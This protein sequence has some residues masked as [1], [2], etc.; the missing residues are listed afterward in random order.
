MLSVP[1]FVRPPDHTRL[2]PLSDWY[3]VVGFVSHVHSG[4]L[5][6]SPLSTSD[7]LV[8]N[9]PTLYKHHTPQSVWI[10]VVRL[11]DVRD[12]SAFSRTCKAFKQ[13]ALP[14]LHERIVWVNARQFAN[15]VHQWNLD[16]QLVTHV[17][18]LMLGITEVSLESTITIQGLGDHVTH[19]LPTQATDFV[20]AVFQADLWNSESF[21]TPP[22]YHQIHSL[23]SSCINLETLVFRGT[24]V[25]PSWHTVIHELPRL[26]ILHFR[27][28][29]IMEPIHRVRHSR[30]CI[31]ELSL[32]DVTRREEYHVGNP[33]SAIHP[34]VMDAI[35]SSDSIIS[36]HLDATGLTVL[37]FSRITKLSSPNL[38]HLH[39]HKYG[40]DSGIRGVDKSLA[41]RRIDCV[42]RASP[43]VE[44]FSLMDPNL[45]PGRIVSW[46]PQPTLLRYRGVLGCL[47]LREYA[48]SHVLQALELTDL[49]LSVSDIKAVS[50]A[51]P[52]LRHLKLVF[53]RHISFTTP[54][55]NPLSTSFAYLASLKQ[56]NRLCIVY[57]SSQVGPVQNPH[58][59]NLFASQK[60][61]TDLETHLWVFSGSVLD[62]IQLSPLNRVSGVDS[63]L[64]IA[65]RIG[66]LCPSL[67]VIQLSDSYVWRRAHN[68]DEWVMRSPAVIEDIWRSKL[69]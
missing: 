64:Q 53:G 44:T 32:L 51:F 12:I 23:S 65:T 45:S 40:Q 37:P 9:P 6:A 29:I 43:H 62:T 58:Y 68:R 60:C 18:A 55:R 36:L 19:I 20:T 27:S 41:E 22:L 4:G 61:Y 63:G 2:Q 21:A 57:D 59:G 13:I 52:N 10:R 16:S 35:A 48:Y 14:I 30:L 49:T 5:Y 33:P 28:C 66:S 38:R 67:L 3:P 50:E 56:L 17:R 46:Y 24:V 54:R 1:L 15:T 69:L 25:H 47:Q 31:K 26:R 39:I 34:R 42:L 11:L 7:A 8:I